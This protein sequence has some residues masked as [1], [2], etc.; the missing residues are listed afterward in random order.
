MTPQQ[1]WLRLVASLIEQRR[2]CGATACRHKN[3]KR[4][5]RGRDYAARR[6]AQE[7]SEQR[8]GQ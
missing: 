1:D 7:R 6:T 5:A 2:R 4:C 8:A 3:C